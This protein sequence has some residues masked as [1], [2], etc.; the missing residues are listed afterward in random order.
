MLEIVQQDYLT[1]LSDYS[2]IRA[3]D[4]TQDVRTPNLYKDELRRQGRTVNWLVTQLNHDR[5]ISRQHLSAMLNGRYP[6]QEEWERRI[7]QLLG[8]PFYLSPDVSGV[9][10]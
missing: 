3:M 9:H 6:M 10:T 1:H 8:L 5:P 4:T 7:S 2:I